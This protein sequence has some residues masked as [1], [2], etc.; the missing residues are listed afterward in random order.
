M[1]YFFLWLSQYNKALVP[2]TMAIVYWVNAKYGV[3]LPID[4]TSVMILWGTIGSLVT[5]AVPNTK[6]EDVK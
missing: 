4:E 6:P 2:L 5:F 3:E 1:K